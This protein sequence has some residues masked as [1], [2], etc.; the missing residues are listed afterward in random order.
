MNFPVLAATPRAR[1]WLALGA[2]VAAIA[3]AGCGEKKDAAA[4][5]LGDLTWEVPAGGK[6]LMRAG[7]DM[8]KT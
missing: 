7:G 8:Q 6:G 2:A 4:S 1:C 5:P 3:L